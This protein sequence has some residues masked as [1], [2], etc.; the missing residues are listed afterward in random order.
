MSELRTIGVG[1]NKV[2]EEQLRRERALEEK[3]KK[4]LIEKRRK[5]K[6][7]RF[8]AVWSTIIM[9]TAIPPPINNF[10]LLS[11]FPLLLLTILK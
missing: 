2:R 5:M 10:F 11:I 9:A 6:K 1:K 7:I 3:R 4:E 8:V